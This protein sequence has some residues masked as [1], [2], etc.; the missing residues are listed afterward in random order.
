MDFNQE[1]FKAISSSF[2]LLSDAFVLIVNK[3]EK[4]KYLIG[5]KLAELMINIFGIYSFLGLD[6]N[7]AL[8][9]IMNKYDEQTKED[10]ND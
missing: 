7:K 2:K 6:I 4:D 1:L 10:K 3:E 9:Q 8:N 5:E